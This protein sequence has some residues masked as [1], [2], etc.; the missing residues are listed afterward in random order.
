MKNSVMG[1]APV[2]IKKIDWNNVWKEELLKR[3]FTA[4]DC[5]FWNKR[6]PSF[7]EHAIKTGYAEAFLKIVNPKKSWCVLD[8]GCGAGTLAVPFAE[9]VRSVTAVDFSETM[10]EILCEQSVKTGITNIRT[11]KASWEDDWDKAHIGLHDVAIA[12]RSLVVNNLRG[13]IMKLNDVAKKRVY[14]STIVGDGPYDRHIFEAISRELNMGPDYIYTYNLLYQMDIYAHIDFII[15]KNHK[16][17]KDRDAALNSIR[18]ML[19]NMTHEEEERLKDYLGKHLIYNAGRWMM[20]YCN[21]VRWAVLWWE[22]ETTLNQQY[23]INS[24]EHG[25]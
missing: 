13:A 24:G 4:R 18:W 5:N 22:K 7:A 6:A 1:E 21:T 11:I 8:I 9:H 17:Y 19:G 3:T 23:S 25:V 16:T 2:D 10:L 14:I 12:S 20:D 15:E